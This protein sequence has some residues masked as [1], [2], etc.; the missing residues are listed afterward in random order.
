MT[1]ITRVASG[2]ILRFI[3]GFPQNLVLEV[4]AEAL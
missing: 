3:F 2:T 4:Y 1:V